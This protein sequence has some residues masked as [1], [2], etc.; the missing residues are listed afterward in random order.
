MNELFVS[1]GIFLRYFVNPTVSHKREDFIHISC[2]DMNWRF[3]ICQGNNKSS[4]IYAPSRTINKCLTWGSPRCLWQSLIQETVFYSHILML[5]L[6]VNIIYSP[7]AKFV[8]KLKRIFLKKQPYMLTSALSPLSMR[9]NSDPTIVWWFSSFA[10][11]VI[12]LTT[13]A[14]YF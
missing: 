1:W 6:F 2:Q 14:L 7:S 9:N 3:E 4:F 13:K 5:N 11:L 10:A 12:W 8:N